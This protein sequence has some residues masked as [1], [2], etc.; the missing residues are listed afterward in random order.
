MDEVLT[1][2]ERRCL[3]VRELS[4]RLYGLDAA[5][6]RLSLASQLTPQ[7]V[8]LAK[9]S[10]SQLRMALHGL[11]AEVTEMPGALG[12]MQLWVIYRGKLIPR[13]G[14]VIYMDRWF[15]HLMNPATP[16]FPQGQ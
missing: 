3:R 2:E 8:K 11:N 5:A 9:S 1:E 13:E 4:L 15:A 7:R 14:E 16:M 10:D 6:R 12:E